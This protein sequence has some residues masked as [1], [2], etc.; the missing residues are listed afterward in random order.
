MK[1][2]SKREKQDPWDRIRETFTFR[3]FSKAQ[4]IWQGLGKALSCGRDDSGL[5]DA[6]FG[7]FLIRLS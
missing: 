5:L 2:E 7:R 1:A 3:K 4:M 6:G